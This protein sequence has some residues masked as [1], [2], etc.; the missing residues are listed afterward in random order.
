LLRE[1]LLVLADLYP[2]VGDMLR[3]C[4]PELLPPDWASPAGP[5]VKLYRGET[6]GAVGLDT[7]G[8]DQHWMAD[9]EHARGYAKGADGV[10]RQAWLSP[11]PKCLVLVDPVSDEYDW[12]GLSKLEAITGDELIISRLRAGH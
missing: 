2:A 12:E 3:D 10:L 6:P 4:H 5:G 11:T 9:P 8:V 1:C 7:C